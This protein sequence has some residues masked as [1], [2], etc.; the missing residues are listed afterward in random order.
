MLFIKSISS[1]QNIK[2]NNFNFSTEI[3]SIPGKRLYANRIYQ[4]VYGIQTSFKDEFIND[5]INLK[6]LIIYFCLPKI[7][8]FRNIIDLGLK[9]G[10]GFP[11]SWYEKEKNVPALDNSTNGEF[12]TDSLSRNYARYSKYNE[13]ITVFPI[14]ANLSWDYLRK[15]KFKVN[16]NFGLGVYLIDFVKESK[17]VRTWVKTDGS[18]VQ[19]DVV[20]SKTISRQLLLTPSIDYTIGLD[21]DVYKD[22]SLGIFLKTIYL[23]KTSSQ[24]SYF[25]DRTALD[26]YPANSMQIY[27]GKYGTEIGGFGYGAGISLGTKF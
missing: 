8:S 15:S 16:S 24:I 9:I 21:Y 1:S 10:V 25:T 26:W 13:N 7:S 4:Y 14:A 23:S 3:L 12:I 5:N 22:I 20:S 19:G 17:S 11:I 18:G 2:N 27:S 6:N